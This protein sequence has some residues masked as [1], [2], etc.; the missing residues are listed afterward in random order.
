MSYFFILH[1]ILDFF[2]LYLIFFFQYCPSHSKFSRKSEMSALQMIKFVLYNVKYF[3]TT[4]LSNI[5]FSLN[6][7]SSFQALCLCSISHKLLF[8]NASIKIKK[9]I[10]KFVF[11]IQIDG[12]ANQSR[13]WHINFF[14][15]FLLL[16]ILTKN[17]ILNLRKAFLVKKAL[18]AVKEIERKNYH[19]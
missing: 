3:I 18:F 4:E 16:L 8:K 7:L 14:I 6:F 15:H 11:F 2:I 5:F 12:T 13:W 19:R 17:V 1:K 9:I 10:F